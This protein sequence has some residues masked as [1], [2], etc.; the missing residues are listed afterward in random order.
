MPVEE[1][2]SRVG[3]ACGHG[4]CD[5]CGAALD[6]FKVQATGRIQR[7]LFSWQQGRG[8]PTANPSKPPK[9]LFNVAQHGHDEAEARCLACGRTY[10]SLSPVLLKDAKKEA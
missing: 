2:P 3:R 1:R 10:W 4:A 5:H 9:P 8:G 7:V 6:A